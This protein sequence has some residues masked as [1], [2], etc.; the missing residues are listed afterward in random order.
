MYESVENIVGKGANADYSIFSFCHNVF[1]VQP[2]SWT[3]VFW[4]CM[5]VSFGKTPQSPSLI[6]VQPRK[7]MKCELLPEYDCN[8]VER[9]VNPQSIN[10]SWTT[11][12]KG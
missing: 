2:G 10:Q 12:V 6:P 8:T 11:E 4:F 3:T 9:G 7:D 1:K 5:G